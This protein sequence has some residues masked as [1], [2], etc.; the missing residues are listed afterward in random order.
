MKKSS[1]RKKPLPRPT[2]TGAKVRSKHTLVINPYIS[3][4]YWWCDGCNSFLLQRMCSSCHIDGRKLYISPPGEIRP[5][6]L[7]TKKML[8][9]F[10]T[11]EYGLEN[12]FTDEQ[13]VLLNRISGFDR[14]DE[15]VVY[16][17][18]IGQ[19]VFSISR[20]KY[21]VKLNGT[22]A[23]LLYRLLRMQGKEFPFIIELDKNKTGNRHI[24]GKK[25]PLDYIL[26]I[27]S[28][29]NTTPL[30][31]TLIQEC[32]TQNGEIQEHNFI[33]SLLEKIKERNQ[34]KERIK[35]S[36]KKGC[37]VGAGGT[38]GW[39]E[40]YENTQYLCTTE[41]FIFRLGNFIGVCDIVGGKVEGGY[42]EVI[43]TPDRTSVE[44]GADRSAQD[45]NISIR[46]KDIVKITSDL[47]RSGSAPSLS[48]ISGAVEANI[49][50]LKMISRKAMD[51]IWNLSLQYKHLPVTVSFSGGKDSLVTWH[52]VNSALEKE[53]DVIFID[54]TLE[55][56]ETYQYIEEFRK[57]GVKIHVASPADKNPDAIFR[58]MAV[59]GP[60]AKDYRW[61]C[62]VFKLGPIS[63]F[64][65]TRYPQ[66]ALTFEGKRK[67]ES[68]SRARSNKLEQNPFVPN[69]ISAYP[70]R[71]WSS[72]EVWLYIVWQKI[73]YNPLYDE[74]YERIGC[75]MCPSCTMSEFHITSI[76]M[77]QQYSKFMAA[78]KD[79][80][81]SHGIDDNEVYAEKG[82][83]RWKVLPP[84]MK[85]YIRSE[86]MANADKS[87][88]DFIR[89][90]NE[91]KKDSAYKKDTDAEFPLTGDFIFMITGLN[92]EYENKSKA[93]ARHGKNKMEEKTSKN[94]DILSVEVQ[95]QFLNPLQIEF[96]EV[97]S[98]LTSL[99]QV[100]EDE[101]RGIIEVVFSNSS[102]AKSIFRTAWA[103]LSASRH[104]LLK[105]FIDKNLMPDDNVAKEISKTSLSSGIL[106]DL[107]K[108][109]FLKSEVERLIY[110]FFSHM[111]RA[112]LCRGCLVCL[113]RCPAD[114]IKI[115]EGRNQNNENTKVTGQDALLK[116]YTI[117]ID[118]KRCKACG[119]CL[120]GCL[121]AKY[122]DKVLKF[123][124]LLS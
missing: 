100:K 102:I 60:P 51:E 29:R 124:Y 32:P 80:A 77:P 91:Y 12:F 50:H 81:S 123:R 68:F 120:A 20:M 8:N 10:F 67:F 70:I 90:D 110:L 30:L 24:K 86:G 7:R 92:C 109:T 45:F 121:V 82:L 106:P 58:H 107:H 59:M 22:G 111:L 118:K 119:S 55:F 117:S 115:T 113:K 35:D 25:I 61:C 54:T 78:V 79:W 87:F 42:E 95:G 104:L 112:S 28:N 14:S 19:L 9:A 94:I 37:T 71:D 33:A 76:R 39:R 89:E 1:E 108:N 47:F 23:L 17:Y 40:E 16:G 69:Q 43:N 75:W 56:P 52:L 3:R 64:I 44:G 101:E 103:K 57:S 11:Q 83:W 88:I 18:V 31:P 93:D 63:S 13:L 98:A 73:K 105:V 38:L 96:S 74:D 53:P 15:I 114:A 122:I 84:K 49:S 48:T 27:Y 21:I 26:R 62:K 66:G 65:Q 46:I 116:Q 97:A 99:G 34:G 4:T 5:A 6:S 41:D 36:F 85:E 2:A 72:I